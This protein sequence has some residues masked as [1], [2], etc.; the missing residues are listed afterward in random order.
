MQ[1]EI[2][3]EIDQ[4]GRQR[5]KPFDFLAGLPV[6]ESQ[7]QDVDGEE[8]GSRR[9]LQLRAPAQ[10]WVHAVDIL[11]AQPLRR[12]LG[13]FHVRMRQQQAQQ[14]AARVARAAYDRRPDHSVRSTSLSTS[15]P[16][17][18]SARSMASSGV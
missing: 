8:F 6:R 7:E 4:L 2:G 10:V 1:P 16:R 13:H 12:D 18:N 9:E 5:E 11:A 15:T 14:L 17:W 3:R